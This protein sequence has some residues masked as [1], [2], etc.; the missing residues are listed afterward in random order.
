MSDKKC[1]MSCCGCHCHKCSCN[2][3]KESHCECPCHC[4]CKCCQ[5]EFKKGDW[6][7]VFGSKKNSLRYFLKDDSII[8]VMTGE[9]WSGINLV[10]S[11]YRIHTLTADDLIPCPYC[12]SNKLKVDSGTFGHYST[13][14]N[15]RCCFNTP[16]RPTAHKAVAD[17]LLEQMRMEH[18]DF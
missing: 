16:Y 18:C 12:K 6:V 17:A 7:T 3:T 10:R 8:K 1:Y 9:T 14:D 13:C 4:N 2:H 11:S 5:P 15:R